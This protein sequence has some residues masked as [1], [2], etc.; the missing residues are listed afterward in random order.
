M[1]IAIIGA[2]ALILFLLI[3]GLFIS[4]VVLEQRTRRQMATAAGTPSEAVEAASQPAPEEKPKAMAAG[5][6]H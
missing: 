4:A 6:G 3:G 2:T 1:H 5:A